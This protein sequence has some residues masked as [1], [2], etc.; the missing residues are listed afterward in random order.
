[1]TTSSTLPVIAG[2][3]KKTAVWLTDCDKWRK[4]TPRATTKALAYKPRLKL[5]DVYEGRYDGHRMI[6]A[7]SEKTVFRV[8]GPRII[9]VKSRRLVFRLP[10]DS[11]ILDADR[12]QLLFRI[13]DDGRVVDSESG[14]LRYRLR[15]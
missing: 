2:T 14:E 6:D 4:V 10:D 7:S 11:R 5:G 9:D 3:R 1:M 12:T 13:R 15:R 8:R